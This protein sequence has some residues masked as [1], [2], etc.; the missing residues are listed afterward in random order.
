VIVDIVNVQRI[1]VVKTENNP[2]VGA[3]RDRPESIHLTFERMRPKAGHVHIGDC[4]G[5]IQ[6]CQNVTQ[7]DL[8]FPV[9]TTWVVVL[10][11]PLEPL[12]A[13]RSNQTQP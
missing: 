13:N 3:N 11:K 5:S 10:M 9:N 4:T 6:P 12:V 8:M 2:P 1:A 7:F